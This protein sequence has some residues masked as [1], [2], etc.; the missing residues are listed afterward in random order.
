MWFFLPVCR[1]F[2]GF[3]LLQI[4]LVY[5]GFL[6]TI[7]ELYLH[8]KGVGAAKPDIQ[9]CC[10]LSVPLLLVVTLTK[11]PKQNPCLPAQL[12]VGVVYSSEYN[13]KIFL[14][15]IETKI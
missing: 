10:N 14:A 1:H 3:C 12:G 8:E 4:V 5:C 9:Q 7:D 6:T 13:F 11:K 2:S 15:K